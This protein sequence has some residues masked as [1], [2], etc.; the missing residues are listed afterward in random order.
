M[1]VHKLT[2]S[3]ELPIAH[4]HRFTFSLAPQCIWASFGLPS[5][6]LNEAVPPFSISGWRQVRPVLREEY[7]VIDG[8]WIAHSS[9][10]I[11]VAFNGLGLNFATI[12]T[13]EVLILAGIGNHIPISQINSPLGIYKTLHNVAEGNL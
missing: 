5:S 1:N 8:I 9:V 4:H 10:H 12:L 3:G 7:I 6:V 2:V 11:Q 13:S